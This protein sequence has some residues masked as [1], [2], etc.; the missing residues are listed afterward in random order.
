M[1]PKA[2]GAASLHSVVILSPDYIY[3]PVISLTQ[4]F[5]VSFPKEIVSSMKFPLGVHRG[6]HIAELTERICDVCF[7]ERG[8][9]NM[10]KIL[11]WYLQVPGRW[12]LQWQSQGFL[13]MLISSR[14]CGEHPGLNAWELGLVS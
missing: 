6:N 10:I 12:D 2:S 1:L 5:L 14:L 4:E 11:L 9:P 3:C 7:D 8:V 13:P